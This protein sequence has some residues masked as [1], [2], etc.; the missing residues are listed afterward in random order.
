MDL[1]AAAVPI[2]WAGK[3]HIHRCLAF[4]EFESE[5]AVN[6]QHPRARAR[7]KSKALSCA[8]LKQGLCVEGLEFRENG[9]DTA[10]PS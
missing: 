9:D 10:N 7:F 2:L 8:V 1:G 6:S 4:W 3:M 5:V